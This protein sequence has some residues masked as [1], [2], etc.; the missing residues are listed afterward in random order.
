VTRSSWAAVDLRPVLA[1]R[2]S[3]PKPAVLERGDGNHLLYPG[4][5]HSFAGDSE[6]LKTWCALVGAAQEIERGNHVLLID[7]EDNAETAVERLRALGIADD[8]IRRR[9]AYV[10]PMAPLDEDD[11]TALTALVRKRYR[12]GKQTT[13]VILDGVTEGMVLH[14]LA[15]DKGNEDVARWFGLLPR[16]LADAGPAV[17]QLDHVPKDKD[18]RGRYAIGG[19]HKLAGLD[20]AAYTFRLV[21]PFAR[22]LTGSAYVTVAK[23]RPGRVREVCPAGKSGEQSAGLLVLSSDTRDGAVSYTFKPPIEPVED[24]APTGEPTAAMAAV[25][26]YLSEHPGSSRNVVEHS[27]RGNGFGASSI[28]AALD[29]LIRD[30]FVREESQTRGKRANFVAKQY[31]PKI[32]IP[33]TTDTARTAEK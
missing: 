1:G 24:D 25:W 8:L 3:A 10:R 31:P 33:Q 32:R 29:I 27:L 19:Q 21:R 2:R 9:L 11:L 12:G 23:D 26:V 28:R 7:F 15:P 20:G 18:N 4:K 30:G 13:L 17:L 5:I 14:G 22:G 16:P 6:S